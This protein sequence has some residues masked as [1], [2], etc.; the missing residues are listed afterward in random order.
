MESFLFQATLYLLAM[1]IAVPLATRAGLGS[2]LGYLIAGILIGPVTGLSGAEMTDLQHFAEFGVVMML[3]LIGLELEPR[4][5]WAM[6]DKLIGLGGLQVLVTM[7]L[8]TAIV[9]A[10]GEDFRV[11][12][13]IGMTLSLSSTAIVLQ[14]LNEKRLMQTAGGRS[15]FAVLLTQDIAVIPMLALMPLL[16]LPG[17]RAVAKAGHGDHVVARVIDSLPA[18][19]VTVI[20][21]AAVAFTVLIGHYLVRPLFR[22]VQGARLREVNTAMALLIVVG[23]A[24]LMNL[25]GLSPALGTFL[26][27]VVLADSEFKHE[28]ESDIEPFKG[29][30]MGLFFITVGAGINFDVITAQPANIFALVFLLVALKSAVLYGLSVLFKIR[31]PDRSLFTLSLAQ[32]GEFG[33]VLV[34]F[35]VGQ[36]ILPNALAEKLLVV[37]AL[38]MLITPLLFILHEQIGLRLRKPPGP[39]PDAIDEQQPIIIAGVGRFGQ[40]VNRLVTMSGMRTTVLDADLKTIQLMRT[41]GFKGYFGDPTRPD[42]L[43]AAGINQARVLVA[44]LDGRE[45]T[46]KLV[47]YARR[48][49]PDLHIVARARDRTH[50][51]DLYRAGANDIVREM[52]DSSL[53]AGR[54]VLEN[55]GLSAFE[56]SELEKLFFKLDRAAVRDLAQVWKPGVPVEQNAEYI[57][58]TKELNAELEAAMMEQ[59]RRR[60]ERDE[61]DR[62]APGNEK[63]GPEA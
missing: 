58:R 34:S 26:A 48:I 12:L 21:L 8:V 24:S 51:F 61:S 36:R 52:F 45:Q 43:A 49:R 57:A 33:F 27:G 42:L 16:A 60:G 6:R 2:V 23:I 3:F 44:A 37:I 50:V 14:T 59:F 56:A 32:A 53:R 41:F 17:A 13:A 10:M 55:A 39:D 7:I 18:W 11:S 63:T 4:A 1:V 62:E 25:V 40:V 5:L 28:M 30:L 15:S 22:F 46:T 31:G 38:S 54:Y 47:A 20:T 19:G 9:M 29:L 35:A